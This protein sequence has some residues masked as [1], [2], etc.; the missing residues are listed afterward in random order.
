LQPHAR[1]EPASFDFTKIL[2]QRSAEARQRVNF[3][4]QRR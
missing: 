1:R 3:L 2:A 4:R